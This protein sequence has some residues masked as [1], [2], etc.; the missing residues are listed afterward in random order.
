[1]TVHHK[2]LTDGYS[3]TKWVA[4]QLVLKARSR[5]LPVAIYRLGNLS[6]DSVTAAWNPQDFNL[7]MLKSCIKIGIAPTLDWDVEMTPVDFV[8]NTI[9][10]MTQ[11]IPLSM[12][13]VF[14]IVN[15]KPVAS[16]WLF[17]WLK[18]HGYPLQ[19][20]SFD[21]WIK[22]VKEWQSAGGDTQLQKLL[23]SMAD[24]AS[25]FSNLST[26]TRDNFNTVLS[27]LN[28]QY[29]DI[30]NQ[31]LTTYFTG[32]AKQGVIPKARK[33]YMNDRPLD[34]KVAIVTGA[35]SGIGS[36]IAKVLAGAGAKVA[37]AARR[38]DK[39]KELQSEIEKDGG[40]AIAVKTDVVKREE[41]KELVCH[42]EY[43]LGPVDIL[44]NNA[45]VM[46]YTMMKNMHED[47]WERQVD[48][49]C[50]GVMNGIGAVLPGMLERKSGH[51]VN[52]S[53]D[54]GR[55]GFAGLAV[56]SGTKFFVEGLSQAMRHEV[57]DSGIRVTCI[58][59][60]DVKTELIVHTTDM[61]AKEQFSGGDAHKI[62]DPVDIGNAV[63][64]AVTQP[65]HVGINEI[66]IEPR[67]API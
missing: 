63:L 15:T 64:Y 29:P 57:K 18:S 7:L 40:V 2:D 53:S 52:M 62:L 56:Y 1:M 39:L 49:N 38:V 26:Y 47:E 3:Q 54:A 60:G 5:G 46:Y 23:D 21:E 65:D 6:G 16:E 61:E 32:L 42:T 51:I 43:T 14:H 27:T 50:K 4:E 9:V 35:S 34:G 33:Y 58:Q 8:S 67:D 31:L 41:T 11:N 24:N 37:M 19:I 30:D 55:T 10:Q 13:K 12:G 28:I 48:I 20:V 59:P 22:R 25:F 36:C 44:V 66:L 17:E 45:G